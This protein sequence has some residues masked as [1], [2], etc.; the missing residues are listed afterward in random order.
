ML[1]E[2]DSKKYDIR[3]PGLPKL[4]GFLAIAQ[5]PIRAIIKSINVVRTAVK[6][7]NDLIYFQDVPKANALPE[8]PP[9]VFIVRPSKFEPFGVQ[10]IE[11]HT[12]IRDPPK[13]SFFESIMSSLSRNKASENSS[14][15]IAGKDTE[16]TTT[17]TKK[18]EATASASTSDAGR[19]RS[20][21]EI[22]RDL[23]RRIDAGEN[24]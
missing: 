19:S 10:A 1:V 3:A 13:K 21:S 22:A 16:T 18:T 20:D 12:F 14:T 7:E 17:T 2:Q 4:A 5:Q 23:Q 9:A 8:L 24:V 6:H 11:V 15:N